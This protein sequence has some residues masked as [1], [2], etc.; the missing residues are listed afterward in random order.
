MINYHCS[1]PPLHCRPTLHT[2]HLLVYRLPPQHGC[3]DDPDVE[4]LVRLEDP[5]RG[6]QHEVSPVLGLARLNGHLDA[7]LARDLLLV[8]QLE[9]H[10][11][12]LAG[13]DI[14][15]LERLLTDLQVGHLGGGKG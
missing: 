12:G 6:L 13:L 4:L 5:L 14:A 15:K 10:D 7:P 9:R 11:P 8:V 2:P 3:E 1:L